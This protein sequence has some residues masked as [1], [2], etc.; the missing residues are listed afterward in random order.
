MSFQGFNFEQVEAN[1]ELSDSMADLI[2]FS[3]SNEEEE[4]EE[5][6]EVV[7]QLSRPAAK[8]FAQQKGGD[9]DDH[10]EEILDLG[11]EEGEDEIASGNENDEE[12]D[13][14]TKVKA[15]VLEN[16]ARKQVNNEEDGGSEYEEE[17][18]DE[19]QPKVTEVK[20]VAVEKPA[21]QQNSKEE[22]EESEC[23][24]ESEDGEQPQI[25]EPPKPAAE[26][27]LVEEK[28]TARSS[29]ARGTGRGCGRGRGG[30]RGAIR[31]GAAGGSTITHTPSPLATTAVAN[32][33]PSPRGGRGGK[34]RTAR[35]GRGNKTANTTPR[36]NVEASITRPP[37]V[38]ASTTNTTSSCSID[39]NTP[40]SSPGTPTPSKHPKPQMNEEFFRSLAGMPNP[41]TILTK[42]APARKRK[43][44]AT[45]TTPAGEGGEKT[46]KK[47]RTHVRKPKA[48]PTPATE[49]TPSPTIVVEE[50]TRTPA[51]PSTPSKAVKRTKAKPKVYPRNYVL[52]WEKIG[53]IVGREPAECQAKLPSLNAELEV[54]LTQFSSA[55]NKVATSQTEMDQTNVN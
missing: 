25:A 54:F 18:D 2:G 10:E 1:G 52:D 48:T 40:P 47:K 22:I 39:L 24:G 32:T 14:V 17:S 15:D 8:A 50:K 23:E 49:P 7:E 37:S 30:G 36:N 53:R 29:T 46:D 19:E 27:E 26:E 44:P 20:K 13:K 42:P 9:D 11:L 5:E 51:A 16:P 31:E 3:S 21:V 34:P 43:T 45:P 12:D 35:V 41:P 28:Q 38:S 55:T 6:E 33:T 4:E